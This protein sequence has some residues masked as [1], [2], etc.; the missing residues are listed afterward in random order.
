MRVFKQKNKYF[1]FDIPMMTKN[2]SCSDTHS[3]H[4]RSKKFIYLLLFQDP[5]FQAYKLVVINKKNRKCT[6]INTKKKYKHKYK[7]INYK[8]V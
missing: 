5:Q 4:K 1:F 3:K 2:R 7:S 8:T 6:I